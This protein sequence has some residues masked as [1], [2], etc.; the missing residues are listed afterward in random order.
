MAGGGS[1]PPAEMMGWYLKSFGTEFLQG[2]GMTETNPNVSVGKMMQK[3]KHKAW[4]D[5]EKFVNCAKVLANRMALFQCRVSA[6]AL[7]ADVGMENRGP[8][9]LQ[10]RA[11][12]GCELAS[13]VALRCKSG[14][15]GSRRVAP[16][17]P[18]YH[19]ELFQESSRH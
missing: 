10:H 9:Q 3:W 11:G 13:E 4:T 15:R 17:R 2:F 18:Y 5:Q 19:S 14:W 12:A 1:M 7:G 8:R 6:R 16:P